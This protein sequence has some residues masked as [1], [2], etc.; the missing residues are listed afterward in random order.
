M[1]LKICYFFGYELNL[2]TDRPIKGTL[3]TRRPIKC[4]LYTDRPI[5]CILYTDRLIKFILYT[6]RPIRCILYTNRPIK[7]ILYTD[8]PIKSIDS[9]ILLCSM[10]KDNLLL[11]C[12]IWEEVSLDSTES[13]MER[14]TSWWI[15]WS[16]KLGTLENSV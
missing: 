8:R 5:K 16:R 6:D 14:N 9:H 1:L 15:W 3:Y 10:Y 13:K 2:Y 7:C 4:T 12:N 11:D